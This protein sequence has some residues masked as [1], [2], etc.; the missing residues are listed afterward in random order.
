MALTHAIKEGIQLQKVFTQFDTKSD[1]L[2]NP[3]VRTTE[4]IEEVEHVIVE[5]EGF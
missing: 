4:N 3:S 5:F 1:L 2:S